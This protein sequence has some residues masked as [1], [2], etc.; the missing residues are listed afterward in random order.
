[1]H[2]KMVS[3][4]PATHIDASSTSPQCDNQGSLHIANIPKR[5]KLSVVENYCSKITVVISLY[6]PPPLTGQ[7]I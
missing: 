1:M 5:A 2:S 3:S 7:G 6:R 4:I